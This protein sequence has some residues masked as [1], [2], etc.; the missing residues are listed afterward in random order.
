MDHESRTVRTTP[1]GAEGWSLLEHSEIGASHVTRGLP[2]QDAAASCQL[3][4]GSVLLCV[5]DGHGSE[6]YVRSDIG[7]RLA[8]EVFIVLAEEF[9]SAA[10]SSPSDAKNTAE[11]TFPRMLDARWREAVTA[12]LAAHPLEGKPPAGSEATEEIAAPA[13][14]PTVRTGADGI[15]AYGSTLVGV[16]VSEGFVVGWQIGDGDLLIVDADGTPAAPLAP[17]NAEL[18]GLETESLCQE[19]AWRHVRTHWSRLSAGVPAL[20]L[21]ST[22]GLANSFTDRNEFL[23]FGRGVLARIREVGVDVARE[24]LRSWLQQAASYSG[25]DASLVAA[26]FGPEAAPGDPGKEHSDES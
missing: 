13:E 6:R 11:F 9:L 3:A 22:D 4:D 25:D 12:H 20:I 18:G 16:A 17:K 19:D 1:A 14:A 2:N 26:W 7:S 5:A 8:T 24:Q 23:D 15:Q 21:L 10:H